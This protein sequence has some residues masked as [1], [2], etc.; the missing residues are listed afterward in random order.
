MYLL[1]IAK[2]C[3]HFTCCNKKRKKFFTPKVCRDRTMCSSSSTTNSTYWLEC[4]WTLIQRSRYCSPEQRHHY[5]LWHWGESALCDIFILCW[6]NI[7]PDKIPCRLLILAQ[8]SCNQR[9]DS[10]GRAVEFINTPVTR[11]ASASHTRL[12]YQK[13]KTFRHE[14]LRNIAY[15]L[16]EQSGYFPR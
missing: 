10:D 11:L 6:K 13:I 9:H 1:F 7:V 8:K 15:K 3:R 4:R 2:S 14:N 12:I 5:Q 16:C